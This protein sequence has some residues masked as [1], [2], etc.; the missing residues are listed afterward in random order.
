LNRRDLKGGRYIAYP[1][2]TGKVFRLPFEGGF[3]IYP[4]PAIG[5]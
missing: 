1:P 2:I 5:I 4:M 3:K